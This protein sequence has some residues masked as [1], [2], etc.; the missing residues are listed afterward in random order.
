MLLGRGNDADRSVS[1]R[2][3]IEERS[4]RKAKWEEGPC[5]KIIEARHSVGVMEMASRSPALQ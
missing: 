1:A 5:M 3:S 4:G 2:E